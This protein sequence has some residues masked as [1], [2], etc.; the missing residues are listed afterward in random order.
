MVEGLQLDVVTAGV[1]QTTIAVETARLTVTVLDN[2]AG[3]LLRAVEEV[4][5]S[6]ILQSTSHQAM[7]DVVTVLPT[8]NSLPSWDVLVKISTDSLDH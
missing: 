1:T 5:Q 3:P 2:L 8:H 6:T 7:E 4:P